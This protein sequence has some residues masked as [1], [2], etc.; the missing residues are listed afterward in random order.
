MSGEAGESPE[1]VDRHDPDVNWAFEA[2]FSHPS[3]ADFVRAANVGLAAHDPVPEDEDT[4]APDGP[5]RSMGGAAVLADCVECG[6][7]C[8]CPDPV[9]DLAK[10]ILDGRLSFRTTEGGRVFIDVEAED[11]EGGK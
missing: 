2:I 8:D 4:R 7:P 10:A 11:E 9:G 5:T 1:S 3:N 6:P